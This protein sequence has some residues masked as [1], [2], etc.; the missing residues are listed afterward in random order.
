MNFRK[1]SGLLSVITFICG[2]LYVFLARGP[3]ID[4]YLLIIVLAIL[5]MVGIL[6]ALYSNR[7]YFVLL[8]LFLNVSLAAF[9]LIVYF[10]MNFAP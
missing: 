2:G 7:W 1:I 4:K 10:G 3:T 5:S 9:C 6:F 8:G